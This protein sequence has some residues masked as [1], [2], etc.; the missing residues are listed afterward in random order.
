VLGEPTVK[1]KPDKLFLSD[2]EIE[3]LHA[4]MVKKKETR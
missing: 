2:W 1:P 4:E 3:S